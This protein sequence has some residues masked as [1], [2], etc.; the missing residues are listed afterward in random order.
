MDGF[1]QQIRRE[2]YQTFRVSSDFITA[3]YIAALIIE[4]DKPCVGVLHERDG[5]TWPRAWE[6]HE[7]WALPI[8]ATEMPIT[9]PADLPSTGVY[10]C[11]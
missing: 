6:K 11:A 4:S 5:Y 2:F 10:P 7:G 8:E 9:S 1:V 3:E